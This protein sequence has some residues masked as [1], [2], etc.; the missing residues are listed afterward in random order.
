MTQPAHETLPAVPSSDAPTE[1]LLSVGTITAAAVAVLAAL[2]AFGVDLD[3]DRQA[4]ILGIVAVLAPILTAAAGRS[5]VFAP[6]TVAKMVAAA[7][8]G[9]L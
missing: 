9:Q 3:D 7:K 2:V 4:A 6:K 8:Q 1:P 5:H